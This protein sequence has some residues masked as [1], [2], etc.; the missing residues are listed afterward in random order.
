MI[1]SGGI[2]ILHLPPD[3]SQEPLR[4]RLDQIQHVLEDVQDQRRTATARDLGA[5]LSCRGVRRYPE[6]RAAAV[7]FTVGFYYQ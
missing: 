5:A 6:P 3:I 7:R 2:A 4:R 1:S